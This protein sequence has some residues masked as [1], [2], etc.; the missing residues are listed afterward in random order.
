MMNDAVKGFLYRIL[1]TPRREALYDHASGKR[2]TYC[3]LGLRGAKLATWLTEEQRLKTGDVIALVGENSVPFIDAFYASL[4]TGIIIT[5]YNGRLR[6][7]DIAPLVKREKPSVTFVSEA[8]RE[9]IQ[10]ACADAGVACAFVSLDG[11]DDCPVTSYMQV[12]STHVDPG[13]ITSFEG[14]GDFDIESTCMLVHTGGTT[15]LPKSAMI[16]YRAVLFNALSEILTVGFTQR[17]VGIIYLPFFHTVGWNVITLPLLLCGGRIVL[18]GTLDPEVL[19]HLIETEH[20]TTGLALE[21]IFQRMASHP[22][23]SNTDFSSYRLITNGAGPI[24]EATMRKFWDHGVKL[25]NAYGMTETGPNN[26]FY[27]DMDASLDE[28]K[29][30]GD[31]VGKAMC[32]NE[33]KIVDADGNE[34][35]VGCDGELLWR[36]PVTFSGY[37]GNPEATREVM[38]EDGWVRSGDMGHVDR[39]GYVYLRGRRKNMIITNGENVFPIEIENALKEF[40]G[41]EDCYVIAVPD[42]ERGEVGKALVRMEEGAEFDRDALRDFAK[43]HLATIKVPVYYTEVQVFPQHGL[44]VNLTELKE[45]YGFAGE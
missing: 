22:H 40:P 10:G 17:D 37:W 38:T 45:Q 41:V 24:G 31:T 14:F 39:C 36:G 4:M 6:T 32:F 1:R 20:P 26:C 30:H 11:Q 18:P 44:K 35:P 34:V 3:D 29:H 27:P 23:F 25:V 42:P 15:G 12:M 21:A 2:F 13:A 8:F 33:L 19:L 28:V 16:S 5:T 7:E 43:E 9:T